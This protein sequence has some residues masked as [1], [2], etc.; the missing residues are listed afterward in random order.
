VTVLTLIRLPPRE[1]GA[2]ID[3]IVRIHHRANRNHPLSKV[4]ENANR[5]KSKVPGRIE[6]VSGPQQTSSGGRIVRTIGI[7]RAKAK[8]G[9]QNLAYNLQHPP[10]GDAGVDGCRIRGVRL[11]HPKGGLAHKTELI[12]EKL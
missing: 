6:H 1:V 10:A 9:L 7:A 3:R 5:Q 12:H 4:Q 2:M 11:E 8:I